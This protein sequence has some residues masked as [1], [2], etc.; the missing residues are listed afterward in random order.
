MKYLGCDYDGLMAMPDG[1]VDAALGE[2]ERENEEH[3]RRMKEI[4]MNRRH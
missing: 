2:I 4:E 3:R 1:Y